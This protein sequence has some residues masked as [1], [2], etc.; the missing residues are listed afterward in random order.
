MRNLN[1]KRLGINEGN[2]VTESDRENIASRN[3]FLFDL[4][5]NRILRIK[6]LEIRVKD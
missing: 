4:V 6:C 1:R 2:S 3:C 5:W